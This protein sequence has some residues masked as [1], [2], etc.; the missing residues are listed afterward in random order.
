MSRIKFARGSKRQCPLSAQGTGIKLNQTKSN[1][2]KL[3]GN[4][5]TVAGIH[6]TRHV[7]A[8]FSRF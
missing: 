5:K 7:S 3:P 4:I 2:L 6:F 8:V 1:R